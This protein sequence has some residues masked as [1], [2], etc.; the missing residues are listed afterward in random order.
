MVR[1]A[2]LSNVSHHKLRARCQSFYLCYKTYIP[3]CLTHELIETNR[4]SG[5]VCLNK[6]IRKNRGIYNTVKPA[7]KGISI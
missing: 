2:D 6:L 3:S 7:L 5:F 4:L 1:H